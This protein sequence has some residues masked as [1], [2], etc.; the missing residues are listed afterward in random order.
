MSGGEAELVRRL[1]DPVTRDRIAAALRARF[2]RDIYPEDVVIADV[3]PG[4]YSS[5]RGLSIA[6]I[7]RRAGTDPAEAA[8]RVLEQHEGWTSIINHAMDPKD[9][10]MVL[11]VPFSSVASDSWMVR[12]R[13]GTAMHPRNVG[14]FTRVL[15][16]YVRERAVLEL[17]DAVRKMTGLPA[18]RMGLADRGF[19]RVGNIADL[20][21]FD[22]ATVR[23]NGT[24]E[25]PW[26]LSTGVGDVLVSG[27]AVIRDGNPTGARP[28]QVL[29]RN[30]AWTSNEAHPG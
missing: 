13:P 24:Y 28:G 2:G 7:G 12:P 20:V 25:D 23:D 3:C 1:G 16:R 5:C 11:T 30:S 10:E 27:V 8:L 14:T 4:R 6:E 9:V 22:P 26:R 17:G 15:G 21:V 29:R 18:M 19:V